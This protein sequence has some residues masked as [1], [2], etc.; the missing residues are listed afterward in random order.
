MVKKYLLFTF[1]LLILFLSERYNANGQTHKYGFE[2]KEGK[3]RISLPFKTYSNLIVVD[4]LFQGVIPLKFIVD[5]GVT[6]TVL[7]DKI[8]SDV[9]D[10]VPDRKIS[11]IGAAG[12]KEVEAYIV[13]SVTINMQGIDGTNIPLLVLK[14][15]YLKLQET[16]GVKIHGILGYDL[17][18]KF[19]VKV[20]YV[21]ETLTFYNPSKFRKKLFWYHS[22]EMKVENTKPYIF[23][24]V[25][26]KD[27]TTVLSKLLIDTGASQGL[28]LHQNSDDKISIPE[29][30]IR[31]VLGAGIAGTIEGHVG[32]VE[33]IQIGKH[34]LTDVVSRFPDKG[35]Y[36]D[37]IEV[38][39]RQGTIGGEILR[40][41]HLYFDYHNEKLY[42]RKNKNFREDFDYDMSGMSIIAKGEIFLSPYYE[43]E[44]VRKNSPA[45][46]AGIRPKDIL[47]SLNG[48]KS[49]DLNLSSIN[50]LLSKKPGK[51]VRVKVKRNDEVISAV[52]V[53]EAAI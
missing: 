21:N 8:Y 18:K 45:Y 31:D 23:S 50:K 41:F 14:E 6:N 11:L 13:N 3:D 20:D 40:R 24:P 32:R 5:T 25:V 26:L 29:K 17:F 16:L 27:S 10:I 47:I 15:D 44:S 53:L 2:I 1:F 30:N 22:I 35:T 28:M 38:T 43:I 42:F 7:I 4:V 36:N 39:E 49:T 46:E 19:I 52:F 37:V 12:G 33:S 9:L 51:K 48:I 34:V